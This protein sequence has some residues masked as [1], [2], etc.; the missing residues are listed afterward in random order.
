MS[1]DERYREGGYI[2][3]EEPSGFFVNVAHRIPH[4]NVLFLGDGYGRNS[5]YLA[6][7][8]GYKVVSLDESSVANEKAM[9]L[10]NRRG[11]EIE[12]VNASLEKYAIDPNRWQGIVSIFCHL[13]P[14][15]R[16]RVHHAAVNGLAEGGVFI[17]QA[18]TPKQLEYRSG[19]LSRLEMLMNLDMLRKDL[20]GLTMEYSEEVEYEVNEGQLHHGMA[21]V[22]QVVARKNG[23]KIGI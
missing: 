11:V 6:S 8:G 1:W 3:G 5:V 23:A 18:Y 14:E 4:G 19:G 20:E 2:F 15:L 9:E 12:T 22:V 17:L 16:S 21:A 7:L 10:A 13:E